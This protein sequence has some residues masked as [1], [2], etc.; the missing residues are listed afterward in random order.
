MAMGTRKQVQVPLFLTV[1]DLPEAPTTPFFEKLS[2]VLDQAGF[3]DFVERVCSRFYDQALGR[4]SLPPGV[5]F[6]MLLLG[7]LMG[8]ES[9]RRIALQAADSLSLRQF[10]GYGLHEATPDHSTL[11]KTRK[12]L[13]LEA[14][15]EVFGWVLG[16]LRE[17]GLTPGGEVAVD[18]TTLEANAALKGLVR[19]E[20][21]EAYREFVLGLAEAA[22]ERIESEGDLIRFDRQRKGKSLSNEE[23]E[24]PVDPDARVAKMKDGTTHLAYKAEHAVDLE[25][26]AL[27]GVTVQRADGGDTQTLPQTLVAV[28]EARGEGPG[29]V[30]LDKGYHSDETLERLEAAGADSYVA[31]P[32]G[33]ERNW[34]GKEAER[35][36]YAEN[37]ERAGS[38][39]GKQLSKLRTEK[40][41]RS[42]AHMY[43]TGG[44]RR[45]WLR[46]LDNVRKRVLIH[47]CGHNLGVLM[48]ELTGTGTPR[49]LQGQG[50][51]PRFALF[52]ALRAAISRL[53]GRFPGLVGRLGHI[54]ARSVQHP[55]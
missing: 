24:S 39:R 49:S 12:R 9:E 14:H 1:D 8:F 36:R 31:V 2:E 55:G 3:D 42:M 40:A 45:L 30:V 46:G 41:E 26:G 28:A 22:G 52:A 19:N 33:P 37:E 10:L 53:L 23:W 32:E 27:V 48:R 15:E 38:E 4:P 50:R 16:R 43:E 51:R 20:T 44:M 54:G 6:R 47:A 35:R 29:T 25:S 21:G 18:A 34:K 5:Y 13:A 17:A 11:S 7:Y